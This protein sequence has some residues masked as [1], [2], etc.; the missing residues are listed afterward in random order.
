MGSR[1]GT[2]N[3]YMSLVLSLHVH[4]YLNLS[5]IK[6]KKC[7]KYRNHRPLVFVS[8][9]FVQTMKERHVHANALITC[10]MLMLYESLL[11]VA[12]TTT[13]TTILPFLFYLSVWSIFFLS[14]LQRHLTCRI[15]RLID[16]T[17]VR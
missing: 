12:T 16:W 5:M 13:T 3:S 10:S 2:R 6:C 14:Q 9:R 7:K 17:R 8:I 1:T 15:D 4:M 11:E